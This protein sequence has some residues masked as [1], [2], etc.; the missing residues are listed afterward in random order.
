MPGTNQLSTEGTIGK[1]LIL[2]GI[3]VQAIGI[4]AIFAIGPGMMGFG[5]NYGMANWMGGMMGSYFGGLF[6]ALGL[7]QIIGLIIGVY[8]FKSAQ[9]NDFNRA[10]IL[11]IVSSVIPPLQLIMLAGGILCLFS[12]EGKS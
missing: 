7:V 11:A 4:A 10:G 1:I 6:Y 5:Y 3:V 8:A 2:I 9:E 12:K